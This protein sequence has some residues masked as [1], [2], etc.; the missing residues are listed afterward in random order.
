MGP[1]DNLHSV[2][3]VK[4]GDMFVEMKGQ[5]ILRHSL[6]GLLAPGVYVTLPDIK[7]DNPGQQNM[8]FDNI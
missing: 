3:L 7:Q 2:Q 4:I 8:T 6:T 5:I 1:V